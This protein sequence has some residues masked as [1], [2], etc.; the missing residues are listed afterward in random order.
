M[1]HSTN[2]R[3][4]RGGNSRNI[5]KQD[6]D[7]GS[8]PTAFEE[9]GTFDSTNR[10]RGT[11]NTSNFGGS[12]TYLPIDQSFYRHGRSDAPTPSERVTEPEPLLR[13]MRMRPQANAAAESPTSVDPGESFFHTSFQDIGKKLK[14]CNDTLGEL[15]QLGVSHDVQL[16]E[17]VLVGDQSAGK[18]SLMS[19]LANL[20]LPRS[21]GTCTRCP[22]HIRVSRNNDWSCRVW[23][24][25]EYSYQPPNQGS[26]DETDVTD[27][28]P[29][30]PWRKLPVT[31]VHEFKTM[32]DKNEIEDVLRWA[33]IA[34]LNDDKS[35]K[36]F[37]PGSGS[38]AQ[39]T[40][41][42]RAADEVTA[43]FS[44]NIVALEIKGPELPDLSF[45]DMPGIF[46]NPAD[47][48]DDYLVSVVR[49][50]SKDYIKHPSAIILCAMPMNSDAENSSTFGLT[51]KLGALK[52]TIGVLTKADL[53]PEAGNHDQWLSIMNG[54]AHTTG[55]GYFIT[56]RP[57]GKDLDELKAWEEHVF[58]D[59]SLERWPSEFHCFAE[60]C[61]I[62]KL[63]AFLS[64]RL[65]EEFA[66]SLP[67][68]KSTLKQHLV[69]ITGELRKLPELP[70]NVEL[71]VRTGLMEFGEHARSELR[72]AEFSKRFGN[73][74]DNFRDCL[75]EM[76]PKFTLKDASD[77]PVVEISDDESDAGSVSAA[78]VTPTSKRRTMGP[79][80]TPA[81]R[82]RLE[83]PGNGVPSNG[84]NGFI[85][86]E[87]G[88]NSLPPRPSPSARQ[89]QFPEPFTQFSRV[90]RGFRTLRQVRDEIKAKTR[91]GMPD[92]I[93]DEVYNDLCREAIKPWDGPMKAFL[94]QIMHLLHDLLEAAL[95]KSFDRLNKRLVYQESRKLLKGYLDE[96]RK[97][98]LFALAAVYRLETFGLFT[99]N[100]E[101]FNRCRSAE[102]ILL[103]RYR[104][105][106]RMK[107][108]G[109]SD[110]RAPDPWETM[111]EEK[112][113]QDKRRREVDIVKIG[114]DPFEQELGVIAYV[115][116]YY[117]LAALR[118][119]DAVALQI[120]NGMIPE[121]QRQLPYYLDDKLGLRG[122]GAA[123]VYERLM[124]E[125]DATATKRE[126]LK[127]EL[128]KFVK[129][130][131]SIEELETG[132]DNND[133]SQEASYDVTQDAMMSGAI[134]E[135][136]GE[137]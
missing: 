5:I 3:A 22:L 94:D 50:L 112:R 123:N 100:R 35:H 48:R 137:A 115:R 49:N 135:E 66:K 14:A 131:A 97:E 81:K 13:E 8:E 58:E 15:Q 110:G 31:A 56:S 87:E 105:E 4:A 134:Q 40:P 46:Q 2:R 30:Y 69:K 9:S 25:K 88:R 43:K 67:N 130:L 127:G 128:E 57:Q 101:A 75:L 70:D 53:I 106:M 7:S 98:T 109:Y 136:V 133:F 36:L 19:G 6:P 23:L 116:G 114:H 77:S 104:H 71:E 126:T 26:I 64:E 85:K 16:P 120:T 96:R 129:A 83:V 24:R 111:T 27:Q 54:E 33:Q 60:R 86:P 124:E 39:N 59:H 42:A 21:E 108:H 55:L 118:F 62:E 76:K 78:A 132:T 20:E 74:P 41:I 90:G 80:T 29:F 68:I 28:D 52:R 91:A 103:T 113:T 1:P 82:Q 17:L 18:S 99:I 121:I 47:A 44:P 12:S 89:S 38:I 63:K 125:D 117:R 61:G 73:L 37:I 119:A 10:G 95:K 84:Q 65:G 34:I 92:I 79:P 72:P 11:S 93:T 32:H 51:R 45:Y 122:P 102:E 107:A